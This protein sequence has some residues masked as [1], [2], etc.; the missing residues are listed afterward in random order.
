MQAIPAA[1]P[2]TIMFTNDDGTAHKARRSFLQEGP[3]SALPS[4]WLIRPERPEFTDCVEKLLEYR[5][6]VG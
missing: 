3:E 2:A 4:H 6:I 5:G 1:L